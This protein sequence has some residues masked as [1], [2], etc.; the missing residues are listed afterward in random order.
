MQV[1]C[2]VGLVGLV[3]QRVTALQTLGGGLSLLGH[4]DLEHTEY[5]CMK[6]NRWLTNLVDI[7]DA[8]VVEVWLGRGGMLLVVRLGMVLGVL[9]WLLSIPA[10]A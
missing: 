4:G 10:R 5:N 6:N 9:H 3:G 1:V 2:Q 7:F 8:G